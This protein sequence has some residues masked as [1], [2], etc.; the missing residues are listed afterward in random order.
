MRPICDAL[1]SIGVVVESCCDGQGGKAVFHVAMRLASFDA[2][3]QI[4]RA[5]PLQFSADKRHSDRALHSLGFVLIIRGIEN[6]YLNVVLES[7]PMSLEKSTEVLT[8]NIERLAN[9]IRNI[10]IKRGIE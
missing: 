8:A 2:L 5:I 1:A 10:S 4:A 7:L 6:G 9:C 3:E